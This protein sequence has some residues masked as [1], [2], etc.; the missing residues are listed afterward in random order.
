MPSCMPLLE[1]AGIMGLAEGQRVTYDL[2]ERRDRKMSAAHHSLVQFAGILD[3]FGSVDLR[4][5]E[6]SSCYGCIHG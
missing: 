1:A 2:Q 6:H 3:P 4:S 5:A